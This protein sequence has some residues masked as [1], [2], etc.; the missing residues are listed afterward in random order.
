MA[1]PCT[2]TSE[3]ISIWVKKEWPV[4]DDNTVAREPITIQ[5]YQ[6]GT[7]YRSS[8]T[9]L[10][11]DVQ[12]LTYTYGYPTFG[13]SV[14]GRDLYEF[15]DLPRKDA[16]GNA[17]TY[18]I[19]EVV[20][21]G[22]AYSI[23]PSETN[24]HGYD[25]ETQTFTINPE[26]TPVEYYGGHYYVLLFKNQRT[27]GAATQ[28][29]EPLPVTITV[30][31]TWNDYD[32]A[33]GERPESL[34]NVPVGDSVSKSAFELVATIDG[35][36]TV[37]PADAYDVVET[38]NGNTWTYTFTGAALTRTT[39]EADVSARKQIYYSV[40]EALVP[41]NYTASDVEPE[42]A[43]A[44]GFGPVS[45]SLTN[46]HN[47][48]WTRETTSLAVTKK[49]EDAGNAYGKRPATLLAVAA[50][51]AVVDDAGE[52]ITPAVTGVAA[53]LKVVRVN[54]VNDDGTQ[55]VT[56]VSS[57]ATVTAVENPDSNTW[58]Y[59]FSGLPKYDGESEAD[60]Q[61]I[62]YTVIETV[63]TGSGL[64]GY[65]SEIVRTDAVGTYAA[66]EFVPDE[67]A[68]DEENAAAAAAHEAEQEA[69]YAA[70]EAEVA[71]NGQS[72]TVTNTYEEVEFAFTKIWDTKGNSAFLPE[73]LTVTLYANGVQ[74][75]ESVAFTTAGYTTEGQ[76][77]VNTFKFTNLPKYADG[78]EIV[79]SVAETVPENFAASVLTDDS[80]VA[81]NTV[82]TG[83][84]LK[85]VFVIGS[86]RT[87]VSVTK[88]WVKP[89]L[90]SA[91]SSENINEYT[92][93]HGT[94]VTETITTTTAWSYVADVPE[95]LAPYL[96]L[97]ANGVAVEGVTAV[98]SV[99]EDGVETYT[100]AD[101]PKYDST[102]T[103]ITYTVV[104]STVDGFEI[105]G[106]A[107][108]AAGGAL[109]NTAK[110]V[111]TTSTSSSVDYVDDLPDIV[112]TPDGEKV[113]FWVKVDFE[114]AGSDASTVKFRIWRQAGENGTIEPVT[115]GATYS[116]HSI[117]DSGALQ[118]IYNEATGVWTVQFG[119]PLPNNVGS[120]YLWQ[121]SNLDR[122]TTVNGEK[123]EYI[124][125]IE[126]LPLAGYT[127]TL[128]EAVD[129]AAQVTIDNITT[130]VAVKI[131]FEDR[132]RIEWTSNAATAVTIP[133][134]LQSDD[135]NYYFVAF[136][137]NEKTTE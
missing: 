32:N 96:T 102:F 81:G 75:G 20:T 13:A 98:K 33:A 134:N 93:P 42:S 68:T 23:V 8:S 78:V 129:Q 99:T 115:T 4:N 54:S 18:T 49:W 133:T 135:P 106:D 66:T 89:E 109:V 80:F 52:V 37:L 51:E 136:F 7:L 44:S 113:N 11:Y 116:A 40:R 79:Y 126:Q 47:A 100:F 12:A 71:A 88:Q 73:T 29:D 26:T 2:H 82:A 92:D 95:T 85:N 45:F 97:K 67:D 114:D 6:N 128:P 15:K 48:N 46:S 28:S 39:G 14:K 101:L 55:V 16:Q 30:T 86:I 56:D 107:E 43:T 87:E 58:T 41:A 125:Y 104:E 21:S 131:N 38:K 70:A 74:S 60:K 111:S 76:L 119:G 90:P 25:P 137:H 53:L 57:S 36:S 127:T 132:R 105:T 69:A 22:N 24:E 117:G 124:Y 120:R 59:T 1:F 77:F 5:L 35:E 94:K 121:W 122:Y 61:L 31:K 72:V 27:T 63:A 3:K 64:A 34:L 10:I 130:G 65:K 9:P 123:V 84:T 83:G 62:A 91:T 108:V 50:Q 17:Y 112:P 118:Y 103:E 110:I 19:K